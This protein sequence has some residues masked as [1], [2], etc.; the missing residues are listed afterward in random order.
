[1]KK[2]RRFTAMLLALA[3][4]FSLV[5]SASAATPIPSSGK[6]SSVPAYL[7]GASL[8]ATHICS[9]A[10][11]DSELEAQLKEINA[12]AENLARDVGEAYVEWGEPQVKTVQG[13]P[14]NQPSKG[15]YFGKDGGSFGY[16]E[17]GGPTIDVGFSFSAPF[18]SVSI[19]APLGNVSS[20]SSV[21]YNFNVPTN[22]PGYYKLYI[23]KWI[24]VKPYIT[25]YRTGEGAPW[26]VAINSYVSSTERIS[27]SII[28]VS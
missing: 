18:T 11:K 7:N 20:G 4:C 2:T 1:M 16:S 5:V 10:E 13:Y 21:S 15:T 24:Q 26:E 22:S 17:T 27:S 23:T 28:K 25:Y 12:Y 3:M 6:A 19:S 14:G 9:Q 8:V